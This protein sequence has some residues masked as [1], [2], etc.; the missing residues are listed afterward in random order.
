M[1]TSLQE[2]PVA[3]NDRFEFKSSNTPHGRLGDKLCKAASAF[4]NSGGGTFIVG[5]ND[6][7]IADGGYDLQIGRMPYQ[8]WVDQVLHSV[9]PA[10][11]YNQVTFQNAYGR[12]SIDVNKHVIAIEFEQSSALPHMSNDNKYYIRA[13]AHSHPASSHIV[14]SLW[15]R[16]V[17]LKPILRHRLRRKAGNPNVIQL[18]VAPITD[19]PAIDVTLNITPLGSILT[20]AE[21][22]F[23]LKISL[24]DKANPFS[25]DVGISGQI[26]ETFGEEVTVTIE[27]FD[28][29]GGHHVFESKVTAFEGL[30]PIQFGGD[31]HEKISKALEQIAKNTAK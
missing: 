26:E 22:L 10:V 21:K 23:P 3:E 24:I 4:S 30:S 11:R 7:G 25:M 13:G 12:G 19:A 8:E 29:L 27:Y 6:E 16:R 31:Y 15:A 28:T 14:E 9:Q 20:K 2:L 18:V 17:Y 1:I 5:V